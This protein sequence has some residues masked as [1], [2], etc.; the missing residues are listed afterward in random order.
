MFSD[1]PKKEKR[2]VIIPATKKLVSTKTCTPENKLRVAAYARVSTDSDEQET[3]LALQKEVYEQ[4]IKKR[5]DWEFAGIYH[6]DGITGT[7]MT[8]RK[9]FRK[10]I[11]DAKAG[12]I[13]YILTKSVARFA[14]NIVDSLQV[15]RE[16]NALGVHIFFET[17]NLDTSTQS[18]EMLLAFHSI[19]AQQVSETQSSQIK[20]G[21]AKRF[22]KGEVKVNFRQLYGYW[23]S[24][25]GKPYIIDEEAKVIRLINKMYLDFHSLEDIVETLKG[26]GCRTRN[27]KD[28]SKQA[29]KN[30][31]INEK[32]CGDVIAQKTYNQSVLDKRRIND[33]VMDKYYVMDNH[34]AIISR[35]ISNRVQDEMARR[36]TLESIA[37][38]KSNKGQFVAKYV[39]SGMI[40]C[41]DCGAIY[42]RITYSARN[43]V[44]WRCS[45]R[46]KNGK[47]RHCRNAPSI[48]NDILEYSLVKLLNQIVQD[49]SVIKESMKNDIRIITDKSK[50][51]NRLSELEKDLEQI[52]F[53]QGILL[54]EAEGLIESEHLDLTFLKLEEEKRKLSIEY[55]N[56]EDTLIL[57]KIFENRI[58]LVEEMIDNMT[59]FITEFDETLI[60]ILIEEI[61]VISI[62]ELKIS[63]KSGYQTLINIP[64]TKEWK[65]MN[66]SDYH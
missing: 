1:I 43:Q 2:V 58:K 53:R 62:T 22:A 6:D 52:D 54:K 29:I 40:R 20:W 5:L 51:E 56:I 35:E 9:G 25:G 41:N 60:R 4:K 18:G 57:S 33:G 42:Q 64:T 61:T 11:K 50:Q 16:L 13:D 48:D 36:V 66:T 30:I 17:E 34:P 37:G 28:W 44:V 38:T 65:K 55:R 45:T 7:S 12:K 24:E 19:I 39:L 3:S 46:V 59:D 27:G 14:R 21:Y 8:K 23:S 31:L 32:Y 63:F 15:T 26:K 10:L 47:N 49:K